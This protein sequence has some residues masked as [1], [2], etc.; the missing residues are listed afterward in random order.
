MS[1]TD[2]HETLSSD[3]F[4]SGL[5]SAE[6]MIS[7]SEENKE[8]KMERRFSDLMDK[9][10]ELHTSNVSE[11]KKIEIRK[12]IEKLIN[13]YKSSKLVRTFDKVLFLFGLSRILYEAFLLGRAPCYFPLYYSIVLIIFVLCRFIYYRYMRWHYFLLD[14]CYWANLML[15]VFLWIYPTSEFLFISTY[16]FSMG[17]LLIAV[18]IFRNSMVLHS[19]EKLTS[20][21]IHIAPGLV[22]WSIRYNKCDKWPLTES[23]PSLYNYIKNTAI[24]YLIWAVIYYFII[25]KLTLERCNK[26]KNTTMFGYLLDNKDSIFY[27]LTGFLGEKYRG[28]LFM[29]VHMIFSLVTLL[30]TYV[31]L[32][33]EVI[34]IVLMVLTILKTFWSAATYYMEIFSK[35]YELRLQN[36]ESIKQSLNLKTDNNVKTE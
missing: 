34:H 13:K 20:V 29:L 6:Y 31:C 10:S 30:L 19:L 27:K 9:K 28:V 23:T 8:K 4:L 3:L 33:S 5:T 24:L 14:F 1:T 36:L 11:P 21:Y 7:Q 26:K 2:D 16:A 32:Y 22:M 35:N 18:P 15:L 17:P 25:F 12:N